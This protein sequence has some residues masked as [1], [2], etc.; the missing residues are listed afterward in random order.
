MR[1]AIELL[2]LCAATASVLTAMVLR[3]RRHTSEGGWLTLLVLAAGLWALADAIEL[4]ASTVE[5]KR[6]AS[7]F[8]YF[9]VVSVAPL[10]LHSALVLA[11]IRRPL[12]RPVLLAVWGIPALTLIVAWTSRWH[13]WLWT[14]IEIPNPATNIGV[15]H[16]GWWFW[17]FALHSYVLL[18]MAAVVLIAATR[19]VTRAFR[20]PLSAVL[21][22]V[23]LPGLGNVAYILKLGPVPGIDWFGIS[24]LLSGFIFAWATTQRGLLDL[25]PRARE[26]LIES[27]QDGVILSDERDQI[28]YSNAAARDLLPG[29]IDT[30]EQVPPELLEVAA[31]GGVSGDSFSRHAEVALM[32][33]QYWLDVRADPLRDRYHEVAGRIWVLRNITARKLLEAEK[34]T[35]LADLESA[36]GTV[37]KLEGI[38]PICA[39]CRKI[40][41]E[42]D[43][44]SPIDTYVGRHAGV[45]FTH[46]LCPECV[47]RL[48]GEH[49][50]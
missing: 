12:T 40:R 6:L 37:R 14:A 4:Q 11:R 19:R 21:L 46:S 28:I 1:N 5:L 22:A 27:M 49:L 33:G 7:Q 44:W 24:I 17:I 26:A 13:D 48:Y 8:Q 29:F 50:E 25:L 30:G 23:L 45:A 32:S 15:Y 18:A 39:G 2:Y 47:H 34:D 38:L 41:E 43:S 42:D 35:L 10:F 31:C 3:R 9:A 20:L 36:H 16:Y